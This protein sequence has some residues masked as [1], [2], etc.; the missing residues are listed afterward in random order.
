MRIVD[1]SRYAV[2]ADGAPTL[3]TSIVNGTVC[4]PDAPGIGF[5]TRGALIDPL[6][7]RLDG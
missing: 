3:G 4:P 6:R 2:P 7:E 1:I 5:D